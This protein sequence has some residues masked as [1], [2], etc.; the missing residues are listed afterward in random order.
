MIIN[1]LSSKVSIGMSA[2]NSESTIRRAIESVISQSYTNWELIII[3]AN[4]SDSTM[5]IVKYFSNIDHRISYIDKKERQGWMESSLQELEIATGDFFMWLDADD[6]ISP[7]WIEKLLKSFTGEDII[8]SIGLLELVDYK[9]VTVINNSSALRLFKFTCSRFRLLRV[10]LSILH[11]ESFG[12]VNVMYGLWRTDVV[13]FVRK[14]TT[15]N[16]D[17]R[18]DQIFLLNALKTGKI[19]YLDGVFHCRTVL[20]RKNKI[21]EFLPFEFESKSFARFPQK[22]NIFDY[23]WRCLKDAPPTYIYLIWIMKENILSKFLYLFALFLRMLLASPAYI[24]KS[25]TKFRI[26]AA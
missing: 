6:F 19:I 20:S 24:I 16:S 5:E 15:E 23:F 12:L 2:F 8:C 14:I 3:D 13:K 25:I 4:S 17:L 18:H 11:P 22:I 26:F 21:N 9:G 10:S 7:Q 1:T